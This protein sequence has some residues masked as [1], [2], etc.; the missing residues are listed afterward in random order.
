MA[1]MAMP[2]K[3]WKLQIRLLV[4]EGALHQQTHNFL[5]I[6]KERRRKI[7]CGSQMGAWHQ[8]RLADW[9]SVIIW[10]WLWQ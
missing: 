1:A 7:G 3:N 2:S 10:L 6:I 8:D 4:R 5:K 9:Q